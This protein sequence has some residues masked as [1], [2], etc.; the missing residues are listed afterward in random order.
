MRKL[1][2]TLVAGVVCLVPV[3]VMADGMPPSEAKAPPPPAP[4][5]GTR[6]TLSDLQPDAPS[7]YRVVKGDTLWGISG[8]FLKDPW[9][10]PQIW[11]MNR[12]QIKDP[13]WIYPGDLIRLDRSGGEPRLSI[14]PGSAA[15][16][17]ANVVKLNPKVRVE[18][19]ATAI[20]TIPANIIGPFLTHPLVVESNGAAAV[21]SVLGVDEDRVI[22]GAGDTA[23]AD[24][25][26]STDG[27]DWQIYRPAKALHD[28]ETGELLG[29]EA[30]YVGD[31]KVRRYGDPTTIEITKARMEVH[32]GDRLAPT[33]ET[34]FPS[35]VPHAPDRI[36]HGSIVGV[37][38]GVSELGQYQIVILNRGARDG[39]EPGHVLASYRRG[40]VVDRPRADGY[41][42]PRWMREYD[43]K[44]YPVV[45]DPPE[46]PYPDEATRIKMATGPVRLPDERNG[47]LLVFRVFDRLSYALVMRSTR[48]IYVGD[49]IQTP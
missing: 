13:H 24:R 2:I 26:L 39:L 33:H 25:I 21:P 17:E 14:V 47:V 37:D 23:Y 27:T 38:G 49:A 8:R 34:T 41:E 35:Y 11:Q 6:V 42:T 16:A 19:L 31:A 30:E 5:G 4:P 3:G 10:W 9:K 12:Q 43:V 29:Y 46:Q 18:S 28:P 45:P 22:L 1:I 48:P 15:A 32:R 44:P 36:V 7:E 40:R 20:P